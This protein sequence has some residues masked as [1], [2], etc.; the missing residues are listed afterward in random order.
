MKCPHCTADIPD[1]ARFCR[2]CGQSIAAMHAP[3]P[4][5]KE[6]APPT[7][8]LCGASYPSGTRFCKIDGQA[9]GPAADA[10]GAAAPR[11]TSAA[12]TTSTPGSS[13]G[14]PGSNRGLVLAIAGGCVFVAVVAAAAFTYFFGFF[15]PQKG[16]QEVTTAGDT[17]IP[18]PTPPTGSGKENRKP[19]DGQE[20]KPRTTSQKTEQSATQSPADGT[21]TATSP[22]TQEPPPPPEEPV[23]PTAPPLAECRDKICID[24]Y[25]L[26]L[27]P[28]T[29][30]PG[31]E[32]R[33]TAGYRI[34]QPGEEKV[35]QVEWTILFDGR[36]VESE[37]PDVNQ[38]KNRFEYSFR[39]PARANPGTYPVSLKVRRMNKNNI[40]EAEL[41]VRGPG[42]NAGIPG[43]TRKQE[44]RRQ[45][46]GEKSGSS[47]KSFGGRLADDLM[48]GR[49]KGKEISPGTFAIE[50]EASFVTGDSMQMY[51]KWGEMA[52]RSCPRGYRTVDRQIVTR[53]GHPDRLIG[54]VECK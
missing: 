25:D 23:A 3:P 37:K 19:V 28:R 47:G 18:P 17:R 32:V 34:L 54:T 15:P 45:S 38:G 16:G 26:T 52:A 53:Q 50:V 30:S 20:K 51:N 36:K 46:S 2:K 44:T 7:C 49:G 4:S 31:E 42:G 48:N 41:T 21:P 6:P 12:A 9:L 27:S 5:S 14:K 13:A 22:P 43:E 40:A 24:V 8:A 11:T 10:P 39:V 1:E 35:L 33:L 29:A